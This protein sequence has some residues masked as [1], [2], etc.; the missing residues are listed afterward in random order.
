MTHTF[1]RDDHQSVVPNRVY[2]YD[3][4]GRG[5]YKI[6][7]LNHATVGPRN[8]YTTAEDFAKWDRNFY[9][10]KVGGAKLIK[11]MQTPGV[12]NNGEKLTFTRSPDGAVT[13]FELN[14]DRLK[15]VVFERV[16]LVRQKGR[17]RKGCGGQS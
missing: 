5:E 7:T 17:P 6:A 1:F 11:K 2:S 15:K 4:S 3:P 13:G 8:L 16:E 10:G 12:L 14:C 9:N